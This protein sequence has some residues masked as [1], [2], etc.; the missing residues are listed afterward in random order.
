MARMLRSVLR[1]ALSKPATRPFPEAPR[2]E[3]EKARG[4]ITFDCTDCRFC[5]ACALKCPT[6]AIRVVREERRIYFEPFKCIVC[7]ACL[8]AC[9]FGSVRMGPERRKPV[10]EKPVEVYTKPED[11]EPPTPPDRGA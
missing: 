11:E 5:G 1:N 9:R 4:L 2:A 8:E 3:F 6:G 10:Y 7:G